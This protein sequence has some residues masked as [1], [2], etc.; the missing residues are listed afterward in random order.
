[1]TEKVY[2]EEELIGTPTPILCQLSLEWGGLERN[3]WQTGGS[4]RC[5]L[6]N[7]ILCAQTLR[8]A[9]RLTQVAGER[10]IDEVLA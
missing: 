9:K 3:R 4:F 1:M 6:V 5:A 2:T 8:E 7:Y 10:F